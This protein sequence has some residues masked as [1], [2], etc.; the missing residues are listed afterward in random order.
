[1]FTLNK[2]KNEKFAVNTFVNNEP[3]WREKYLIFVKCNVT[4]CVNAFTLSIVQIAIL[5]K[6]EK[7]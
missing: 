2:R 1:M 4:Y 6:A 7:T 3:L 5:Q